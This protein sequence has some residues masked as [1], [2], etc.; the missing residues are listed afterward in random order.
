MSRTWL[1]RYLL[2]QASGA[3]GRWW[4]SWEELVLYGLAGAYRPQASPEAC[5][6]LP[7]ACLTINSQASQQV[8]VIAFCKRVPKIAEV[9]DPSAPP[10]P[11]PPAPYDQMRSD[12]DQKQ[13][14]RNYLESYNATQDGSLPPP[15]PPLPPYRSFISG[16]ATA[17]FNDVVGYL[18]RP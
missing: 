18:P 14:I 3:S 11:P 9:R 5:G 2:R 1:Q 10:Q 17:T 16:P 7:D 13:A 15:P 4:R 6:V 8:V 12:P